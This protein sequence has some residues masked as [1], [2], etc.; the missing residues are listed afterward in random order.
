[1]SVL[2][3]AAFAMLSAV[4]VMHV[5]WGFGL[6]WPA[7][8]ER[9][10]VA[11]VVGATGRTR[12]PAPTACFAAAG[13]IFIAGLVPLALADILR[14][15][16]PP[17][18]VTVVGLATAAVFGTR[19]CAAYSPTWRRRFSQQPFAKLDRNWYGPLCL[20]LA[21]IM[22]LLVLKRVLGQ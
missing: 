11:M 14:V 2:A 1:M 21:A 18:L 7:H 17:V 16:A 22:L 13:A 4:A 6:R 12:M 19:G 9:S 8:D 3:V 10:L 5:L 20:V 15:A